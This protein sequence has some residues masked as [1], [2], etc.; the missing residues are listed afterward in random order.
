TQ[1]LLKLYDKDGDFELTREESGFD[2]ETFRRLDTDGDGR[3]SGEELDAWRTGPPDVE[4]SL[5]LAPK[6]VDCVAEMASDPAAMA[7]R[8]FT[9]QRIES[10]RMVIRSARQVA[11]FWAYGAVLPAGRPRLKQQFAAQ[12][13]V[14]AGQKGYVEE[15]DL[16]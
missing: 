3:L 1:R 5:S 15:K 2:E 6:A 11:E 7:A 13:Q 8:G 12:F 14:A 10:G 16:Y 9:A 4:V